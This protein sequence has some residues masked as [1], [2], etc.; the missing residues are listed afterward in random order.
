MGKG[1]IDGFLAP[2]TYAAGGFLTGKGYGDY[3]EDVFGREDK[4]PE[5]PAPPPPVEEVDVAGQ[6]AYTK[7][8]LKN[9]QGRKSTILASLGSTN[10]G[11][12]T[13]LG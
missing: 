9:K 3:K 13:V 4:P 6:K 2:V 11:K 5:P 1:G 8:R 7:A 10:T 12:K